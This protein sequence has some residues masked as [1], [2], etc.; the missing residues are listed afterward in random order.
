MQL[1]LYTDYSFR[2]LLYLGVNNDRLCTI[3]EIAERCNATQNHL[4]KVVH[5]LG[6]EGYI[7]TMR[8]RTGGIRLKKDPAEI[9]ITEIIRCTEVNLD[10]AECLRPT[11]TCHITEVCTLKGIFSEAQQQFIDTLDQ[12]TLASLLANREQLTFIFGDNIIRRLDT[13]TQGP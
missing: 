13:G 8:G 9:T 5:N 11:N 3:A 4:V 2:V 6:K 10:I 1:T 7:Q 12:Y